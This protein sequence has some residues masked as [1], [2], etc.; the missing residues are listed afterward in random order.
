VETVRTVKKNGT[1]SFKKTVVSADG[2]ESSLNVRTT[3]KGNSYIS[4]NGGEEIKF[5]DVELSSVSQKNGKT[6]LKIKATKAQI[7]E[8][9]ELLKELGLEGLVTIKRVK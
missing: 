6:T 9:K 5:K 2:S 4:L 7:G 3:V 1:G 8:I